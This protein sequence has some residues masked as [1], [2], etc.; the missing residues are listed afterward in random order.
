MATDRRRF[1]VLMALDVPATARG[2]T[3]DSTPAM[4]GR[5]LVDDGKYES[6]FL[7]ELVPGSGR[8]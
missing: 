5:A 2:M 1:L 6:T 8:K 3:Q 4:P 7:M